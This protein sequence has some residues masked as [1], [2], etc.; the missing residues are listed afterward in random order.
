M[1]DLRSPITSRP[2][3]EPCRHEEYYI[4]DEMAVF[5]VENTLFKVHRHFLIQ[6]SEVFRGMF[7]CPPRPDGPEGMDD[8]KPIPLPGVL[9]REFERLLDFFY[10]GM[11]PTRLGG[12]VTLIPCSPDQCSHESQHLTDWIELLSISTRFVLKR[13]RQCAIEAIEACNGLNPIEK[14]VLAEKHDIPRWRVP[15]I[16]ALC[17]RI[18]PIGIDE[19]R[20]I[21]L[22]N[23]MLLAH[24]REAVRERHQSQKAK[25]AVASPWKALPPHWPAP[26]PAT[27]AS[28]PATPASPTPLFQAIPTLP[29]DSTMVADVVREVFSPS[30]VAKPPRP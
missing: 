6:E 17:Q 28:F 5:L 23:A 12:R 25:Q 22:E 18:K 1:E 21:G 27:P 9:R 19:A 24:A 20:K 11:Y 8:K 7:A 30:K 13:V 29:Y 26:F 2:S 14:I 10:H 16:E 15:A 4:H 3:S